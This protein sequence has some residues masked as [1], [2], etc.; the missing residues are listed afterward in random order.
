VVNTNSSVGLVAYQGVPGAFGEAAIERVWG[1]TARAFPVPTFCAALESVHNGD[2][3]WAVIPVWNSCVG[4]VPSARNALEA[5]A[6]VVER[7]H[8]IE[9]PIRLALM[10]RP[11]TSLDEVRYVGS[12][13]TALAQCARFFAT[14]PHVK[15]CDASNTAGAAR[16]LAAYG[17][18]ISAWYA[19]LPV[20]SPRALA[21]IASE[22]AARRYE[23]A[24]LRRDVHDDPN[25]R[26]RFAIVARRALSASAS[27]SRAGASP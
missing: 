2:V 3:M 6:H 10:A 15:T 4:D 20:E 8:E 18:V 12:Q 26:T 19:R 17:R 9:I 25:N 24:V 21:V 13:P 1:T 11:G 23:L 22:A 27:G 7:V 16:D 5:H 14:R